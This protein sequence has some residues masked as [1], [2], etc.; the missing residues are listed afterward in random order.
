[1]SHETGG[2]SESGAL[3]GNLQQNIELSA[4]LCRLLPTGRKNSLQI[5]TQ[6]FLNPLHRLY[7]KKSCKFLQSYEKSS[8][9]QRNLFLFLPRWSKFAIFDGKVT[10]KVCNERRIWED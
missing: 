7:I 2:G 3:L 6:K 8:A 10:K 4:R 1:M 5:V 9:K